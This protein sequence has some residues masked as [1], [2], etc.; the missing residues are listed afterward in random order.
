MDHLYQQYGQHT[1]GWLF[2]GDASS[3]S[4]HTSADLSDYAHINNDPRFSPK[5]VLFPTA[6]PSREVRFST[7]NAALCNA[8]GKRR[9]FIHPRCIYLR[10]DL[11]QRRYKEHTREVDDSNGGG[12][13]SDAFGYVVMRLMPIEIMNN[14]IPRVITS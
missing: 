4:R 5:R 8:A 12:H 13:M 7:T 10:E 2:T 6:N 1:G 11:K 14:F 3:A 9:V